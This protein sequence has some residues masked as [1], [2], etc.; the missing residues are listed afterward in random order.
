MWEFGAENGLLHF[1]ARRTGG[2]C[3]QTPPNPQRVSAKPFEGKVFKRKGGNG[4]QG[5]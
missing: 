3:P 5:M 1:H 4:S 2:S